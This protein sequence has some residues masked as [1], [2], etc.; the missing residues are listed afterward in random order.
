MI[1]CTQE[2]KGGYW[3]SLNAYGII[4]EVNWFMKKQ[5]NKQCLSCYVGTLKF[6]TWLNNKSTDWW[7][8]IIAEEKTTMFPQVD[9]PLRIHVYSMLATVNSY[10]KVDSD[11]ALKHWLIYWTLVYVHLQLIYGYV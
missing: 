11:F 10:Y 9:H 4:G 8:S 3:S 7:E 6:I 1:E 5:V 2:K